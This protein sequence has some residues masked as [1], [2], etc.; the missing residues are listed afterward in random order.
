MNEAKYIN[1]DIKH[2][3]QRLRNKQ[4]G[5]RKGLSVEF[6][7]SLWNKQKGKCAITGD[8]MTHIAGNGRLGTNVSIDQILPSKGY[9]EGNVQLVTWDANRMK[10]SLTMNQLHDLCK[11]IL[12]AR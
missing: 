7:Y 8:S 3:L 1:S 11:R 10:G 9:T 12:D 6:L 4:S 2:F 5:K